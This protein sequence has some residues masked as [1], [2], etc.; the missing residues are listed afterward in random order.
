MTGA[1]HHLDVR[2][3]ASRYPIQGAALAVDRGDDWPTI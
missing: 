3:G 2:A 1:L